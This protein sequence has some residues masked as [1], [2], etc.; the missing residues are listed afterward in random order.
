MLTTLAWGLAF[1]RHPAGVLIFLLILLAPF[2]ILGI[3]ALPFVLLDACGIKLPPPRLPPKPQSIKQYPIKTQLISG[4]I[5]AAIFAVFFGAIFVAA[6]SPAP[7]AEVIIPAVAPVY[8]SGLARI[9]A[10]VE[11]AVAIGR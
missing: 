3:L 9:T 11:Q 2:I 6:P 7:R 5:A 1:V 4:G 8:A 10:P